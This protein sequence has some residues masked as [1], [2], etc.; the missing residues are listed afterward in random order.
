MKSYVTLVHGSESQ[1]YNISV[2][3]KYLMG[4]TTTYNM[5][6]NVREFNSK[7]YEEDRENIVKLPAFHIY[8]N[9][10][11]KDTVYN[12]TELQNK[13]EF[14]VNQSVPKK[15]RWTFF[16]KWKTDLIR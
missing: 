11:Y 15:R 4:I 2:F 10:K 5:G 7:K 13:L 1:P 6:F 16:Q 14:I 3:M 8:M 9:G 12:V